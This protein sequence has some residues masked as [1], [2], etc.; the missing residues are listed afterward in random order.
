M[1]KF[2][3]EHAKVLSEQGM[4]EAGWRNNTPRVGYDNLSNPVIEDYRVEVEG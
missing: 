2:L 3:G 1:V 4:S